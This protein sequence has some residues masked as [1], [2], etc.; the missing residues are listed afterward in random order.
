VVDAIAVTAPGMRTLLRA[1]QTH[2]E[3]SAHDGAADAA[4]PAEAGEAADPAELRMGLQTLAGLLRNSDMAA[5]ETLAGLQRQHPQALGGRLVQL[6]ELVAGLDFAPA[7]A[8]CDEL[9][10]ELQ[11]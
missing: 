5:L 8:C 10:A 4:D 11:A 6:D 9:L 3:Q 2:D 7:L 1:L